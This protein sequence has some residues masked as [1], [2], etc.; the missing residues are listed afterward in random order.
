MGASNTT[1]VFIP[2]SWD[3]QV[4]RFSSSCQVCERVSYQGDPEPPIGTSD[5]V[6][7]RSSQST[8]QAYLK[9]GGG[10]KEKR[11]SDA[12]VQG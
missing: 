2:L 10:E 1:H 8:I 4:K 7:A 9:G 3:S 11:N 6:S 5:T 12:F